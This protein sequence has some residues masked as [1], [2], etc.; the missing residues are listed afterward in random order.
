M[1]RDILVIGLGY[2]GS[3]VTKTLSE[4]GQNVMVVD[5]REERVEANLPSPP[6]AASATQRTPAS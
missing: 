1:K 6:T 4:H 2:F 3:R 5:M